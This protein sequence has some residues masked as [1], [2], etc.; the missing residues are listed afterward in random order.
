MGN[1]ATL[2]EF[3]SALQIEDADVASVEL[4][5][6]DLAQGL[7]TEV[8]GEQN[9]WPATAKAIALAAAARAYDNPRGERSTTNTAGPFTK[10][11]TRDSGRIGVYLTKDERDDLLAWLNRG[12]SPVG[13]IRLSSGYPPISRRHHRY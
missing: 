10:T 1:I 4:Y 7:I 3:A 2:E 9:P 8:I 12:R 5:L 6:L 11:A 13:S